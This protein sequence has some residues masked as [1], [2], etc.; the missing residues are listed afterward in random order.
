MV[1]FADF[2]T[3]TLNTNYFKENNDVKVWLW[4][5]KSFD[6]KLDQMGT[7]ISSFMDFVFRQEKPLIYFHNLSFDGDYIIKYLVN[8]RNFVIVNEDAVMKNGCIGVFR[9]GRTIYYITVKHNDNL[10][11]F[12]CSYQLMNSS[13][14]DL[15]KSINIAK[16]NTP[17]EEFYDIEPVATLQ[18]V[19]QHFKEY[20]IHDVLIALRAFK[21]F[22]SVVEEMNP[23]INIHDYITIGSLTRGFMKLEANEKLFISDKESE[24]AKQLFRGGWCQFNP[25][26]QGFNFKTN[27]LTAIDVNSAYPAVM[28]TPLPYKI[29]DEDFEGCTCKIYRLVIKG[30]IRPECKNIMC[31]PNPDPKDAENF[32]NRYVAKIKAHEV[33]LF[34]FELEMYAMYYDLTINILETKYLRMEPFLKNYMERLFAYKSQYKKE[35]NTGM[36]K[37]I[38]ILLNS[39]YGSMCLRS[40][41]PCFLYFDKE[42]PKFF[43]QHIAYKSSGGKKIVKPHKTYSFRGESLLYNVGK[44]NCY[45]YTDELSHSNQ[46]TNI[47]AAAYVTAKQRCK[48]LDVLLDLD[49][50]NISWIYSDTDSHYLHKLSSGDQEFIQTLISD[51]LGDWDYENKDKTVGMFSIYGAKKYEF[52]LNDWYKQKFAGVK[53]DVSFRYLESNNLVEKAALVPRYFKSGIGLDWIDKVIKWGKN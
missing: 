5:I 41:Y 30:K 22:K 23:N 32:K 2:E 11:M 20:I 31:Y 40:N 51:K 24:I 27:D 19:P 12:K 44:Y 43:T 39:A 18:E 14:G 25:I 13:I 21:N 49:N 6:E 4:Y 33:W 26:Y 36:L 29:E 35:K 46:H 28:T 47:L 16:L 17:Q 45:R 34:D 3:T 15:G 42:P 53:R 48:L 10:Y 38:K 8:E 52:A 7:T 9:K 50:P 1:W 37:T